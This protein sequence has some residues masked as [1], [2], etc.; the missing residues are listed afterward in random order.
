ML[1]HPTELDGAFLI[2]PELR[3]DQRGFFARIFCEREFSAHGLVTE[4]VQANNSLT[5]TPGTLRGLHYQLP[6]NAETKLVRCVRGSLWDCIVDL[7]PHSPTH[8]KWFGAE[9]S[10]DNRLM[11]YVPHGFA[12]GFL[13]LSADAEA[14][15]LVDQFYAPESERIVRWDDPRFAIEWPRRP[16]SLSEKDAGAPDFDPGYH[17][18][19]SIA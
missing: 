13:T 19:E 9:L 4:Y 3:G 17:W 15:Y 12:H 5:A 10:A 18:P 1:F 11:M 6:P 8:G 14:L 2:E 16:V 7:R